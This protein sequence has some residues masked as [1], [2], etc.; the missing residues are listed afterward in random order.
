[1]SSSRYLKKKK[2]NRN[3]S[4]ANKTRQWG[5]SNNASV[6]G[7]EIIHHKHGP[8][9]L[10]ILEDRN[11]KRATLLTLGLKTTRPP[12]RQEVEQHRSPQ[13]DLRKKRTT[14]A[15]IDIV[16]RLDKQGKNQATH[17]DSYFR[18][19]G[20]MIFII[21][22]RQPGAQCTK[23]TRLRKQQ[24]TDETLTHRSAT[25]RPCASKNMQWC[26]DHA[27]GTMLDEDRSKRHSTEL[28]RERH[29]SENTATFTVRRL[30]STVNSVTQ[31]TQCSSLASSTR[32]NGQSTCLRHDVRG[33]PWRPATTPH[34]PGNNNAVRIE[35]ML[36]RRLAF[37]R[38]PNPSL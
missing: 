14:L 24:P 27:V 32:T 7:F 29:S 5:Y 12:T 17:F 2:R 6:V 19:T 9:N 33:E 20:N 31:E 37:V 8:T 34:D 28:R 25:C 4:R 18:N 1:M 38:L 36:E 22:K 26:N 16:C 35:R 23:Y 15:K 21:E 11:G 10:I 13:D 3:V 30:V